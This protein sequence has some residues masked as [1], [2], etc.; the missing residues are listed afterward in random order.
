MTAPK[1]HEMIAGLIA[2]P[3]VSSCDPHHD[4]GNRGAAEK[5]AGWLQSLG[6][7]CELLP[8]PHNI[9]KCNLIATLGSGPGGLVLAGHLDTV[10]YDDQAWQSDPF[11]ATERD[12]NLYG[13]GTSD[14]KS[15]LAIAAETAKAF[16]NT[17]LSQPLI[18]LGTADEESSM[19]GA[20]ALIANGGHAGLKQARHAIIGEPT[21]MR[22]IRMN[23]GILM[24]QIRVLGQGGHSSDPKAG[25][26]AVE[27]MQSVMVALIALRDE[28][29]QRDGQT[30]FSI[31]H[32]TMNLGCIHGGDSPN[33]I[34][35]CCELKVDLRFGPD[36]KVEHLRQ[37]LHDHAASALQ[38]TEYKIEFDSL[39]G[40]ADAFQTAAD[41]DLVQAAERLTGH[42][43]G[44]VNFA[45]EA[46]FLQNI[47]LQTIVMG[48]GDIEVAHKPDEYLPLDRIPPTIDVLEKMIHKYC[49]EPITA[50]PE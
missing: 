43:A 48:P 29:A 28:L 50:N 30:G 38:H 1:L 12:G 8:L 23:K 2:E 9:N 4:M 19:D 17:P 49:V 3:S 32:P 11:K 39:F 35:A 10:P 42:T 37:L 7:Q 45:T 36:E 46:G 18:I 15:F 34:P 47:G 33:R 24:E 5:L 16:V 40:G 21:G 25:L 20:R 6:F 14:M 31:V 41:A 26:N 13:L 27:G 22:P 44:A